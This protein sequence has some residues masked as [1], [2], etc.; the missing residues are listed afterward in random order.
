MDAQN[1]KTGET[2]VATLWWIMDL[3]DKEKSLIATDEG[4]IDKSAAYMPLYRLK[5]ACTN[6]LL[7]LAQ[8]GHSTKRQ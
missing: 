5:E 7:R 8:M 4:M 6:E 1:Q 2:R 3:I